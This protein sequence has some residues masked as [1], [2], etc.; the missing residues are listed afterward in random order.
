MIDRTPRIEGQAQ[1]T[2]RVFWQGAPTVSG[3]FWQ[4][5][6]GRWVALY[7][8]VLLVYRTASAM[9]AGGGIAELTGAVA[10]VAVLAMIL[11]ALLYVLARLLA[12]AS[13]YS[14]T[15]S[16]LVI[17]LGVALPMT[18]SLPLG[19]I[20]RAD[21]VRHRDGS[22]DIVLTLNHEQRAGY[23]VMWP[24]VRPFGFLRVRP[25]LRALTDV[26]AAADALADAIGAENQARSRVRRQTSL[27][28]A[29]GAAC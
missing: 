16:H 1:P 24:H 21:L 2:G 12:G 9:A 7:L 28:T 29:Q 8:L 25:M 14:I 20:D 23:I 19:V 13:H 11:G 27:A 15:G 26:D 4:I 5:L 18:V 17:R 3:T 22:G 10:S 6:R